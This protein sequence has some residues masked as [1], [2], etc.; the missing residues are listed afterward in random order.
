[1]SILQ[2]KVL[3]VLENIAIRIIKG[4]RKVVSKLPP[5]L[6]WVVY[7]ISKESITTISSIK[8]ASLLQTIYSSFI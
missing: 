7:K 8:L 4:E 3:K 5:F 2:N 1:M 6:F